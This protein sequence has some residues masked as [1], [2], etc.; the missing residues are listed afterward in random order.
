MPSRELTFLDL[1][2]SSRRVFCYFL[3]RC[4]EYYRSGHD[5][6]LYRQVIA[7][8]R[9]GRHI[10]DLIGDPNFVRLIYRTLEAWNMNQRGARLTSAERLQDSLREHKHELTEL[11]LYKLL[12]LDF[13]TDFKTIIPLLKTVFCQLEVMETKRKI[14]GVSKALHFLL[15]DLVMPIDGEYTLPGFYGYN[16]YQ[17][18]PLAEF[19]EQYRDILIRSYKIVR[20]LNLTEADIDGQ[21][22]NTSAP[23]LIDNALIG[24]FKYFDKHGAEKFDQKLNTL[25]G[26]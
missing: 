3:E 7:N 21:G 14:V 25:L 11:Y 5:L 22:W 6:S 4:N 20:Q 9:Q 2:T 15:P 10:E 17:N 13:T 26:F 16:V 24:A 19:Q 1:A 23:K 8:H 18:T 12:S